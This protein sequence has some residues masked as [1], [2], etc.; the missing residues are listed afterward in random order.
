MFLSKNLFNFLQVFSV[1]KITIEFENNAYK[2]Q[3]FLR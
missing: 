3:Y 2:F 1:T